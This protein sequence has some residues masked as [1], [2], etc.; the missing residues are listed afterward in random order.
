M[1]FPIINTADKYSTR[2]TGLIAQGHLGRAMNENL[3][4]GSSYMDP[5]VLLT[6][7]PAADPGSENSKSQWHIYY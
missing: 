6:D 2:K 3:S 5:S 7:P 1:Q 4:A